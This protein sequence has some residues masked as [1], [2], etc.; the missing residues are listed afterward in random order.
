VKV[1]GKNKQ[2]KK[3]VKEKR[4]NREKTGLMC[5]GIPSL[6]RSKEEEEERV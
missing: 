4:E 3:T 2:E 5:K 6:P 1:V